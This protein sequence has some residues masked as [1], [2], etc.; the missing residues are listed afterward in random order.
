MQGLVYHHVTLA[1]MAIWVGADLSHRTL[2]NQ[3][4]EKKTPKNRL[5][6]TLEPQNKNS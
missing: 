1:G 6:K 5:D 4:S 3:P 2:S